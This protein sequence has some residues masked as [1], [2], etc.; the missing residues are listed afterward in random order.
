MLVAGGGIV[1][2]VWHDMDHVATAELW[3]PA[4]STFENGP[5]LA[6]ARSGHTATLL[7]DGR[8]LLVGG[9]TIPAVRD[10]FGGHTVPM[11]SACGTGGLQGLGVP[12]LIASAEYMP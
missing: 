2:D 5:T 8:I 11:D 12:I 1:S 3:D 9:E 4:T 7:D 6:T 10:C